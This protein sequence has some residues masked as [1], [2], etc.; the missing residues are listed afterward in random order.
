[1]FD[2]RAEEDH[3]C[4][5]DGPETFVPRANRFLELGERFEG[6]LAADLEGYV[7]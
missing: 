1:M 2:R 5:V 6:E 3:G 4:E 7:F